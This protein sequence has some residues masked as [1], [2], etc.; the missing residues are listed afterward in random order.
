M[1]AT[2]GQAL[3]AVSYRSWLQNTGSTPIHGCLLAADR[4]RRATA[5]AEQTFHSNSSDGIRSITAGGWARP[6][7]VPK[8]RDQDQDAT[9]IF[10]AAASA[11]PSTPRQNSSL[12]VPVSCAPI[13]GR[14]YSLL[15]YRYVGPT[16]PILSD[17]SEEY[18]TMLHLA[19]D[20]TTRKAPQLI[21]RL[22]WR[23]E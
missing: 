7:D 19:R 17:E 13:K 4:Q 3:F 10:E 12:H 14:F 15:H 11:P 1:I 6:F 20:E 9:G 21:S 18:T 23:S 8:M 16:S 2:T 5:A 22:Q